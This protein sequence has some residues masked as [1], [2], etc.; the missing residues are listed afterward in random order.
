M[1]SA[2]Q[3]TIAGLLLATV[4]GFGSLFNLLVTPDIRAYNRICPFLA[5]FALVAIAAA[6]DGVLGTPARGR[7]RLAA[8]RADRRALGSDSGNTPACGREIHDRNGVSGRPPLHLRARK[9]DSTTAPTVLQLPFT[10]YL[11]DSGYA[12]MRPYDH[13]KPYIV[14]LDV[15]W[16]YPAMSNR[17]LA[18]QEAAAQLDP[19][20]LT[21]LAAAT[22]YRFILLDRYGY[23]DNAA[24]VL[25]ALKAV[26]GVTFLLEGERY[27]AIDITAV[28]APLTAVAGQ[29]I[30]EFVA[31]RPA[32][33]RLAACG[34]APTFAMD[35]IGRQ[36]SPPLAGPID[37]DGS[38]DLAVAGWAVTP[39]GNAHGSDVEIA[40]DGAPFAAAYGFDRPDVAAY[41][42]APGAQRSGFRAFVPAASLTPGAHRLTLRV[43]TRTQACF[44]E[45]Q[46]IPFVV[47]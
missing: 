25:A 40:I 32:T 23:P 2:G 8:A 20:D 37:V 17:Q 13:L 21:S 14:S 30:D 3:L 35:R 19:A 43:Q 22:G 24:A 29:P 45:T 28:A 10:M 41:L 4:G 12:R 15:K 47:H 18:W 27:V 44:Y 26:S 1:T 39:E 36:T 9:G 5:F 38:R 31:D 11:N 7:R 34:G 46:A 42:K 16:S 6:I 33:S